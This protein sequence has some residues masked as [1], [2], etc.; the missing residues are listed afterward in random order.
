MGDGELERLAGEVLG[1]YAWAAAP[2]LTDPGGRG[3]FSGARL[4]RVRDSLAREAPSWYL[5][6]WPPGEP[7]AD[8]LAWIH[9]LMGRAREAG[10]EWVPWVLPTRGG[11]TAAALGGRLWEVGSWMP[12][13]ADYHDAPSPAR[14]RD[15][16]RVL[17]RLH[18]AWEGQD[19][20]RG[21][22][23]ALVRRLERVRSWQGLLAGGWLPRFGP[24]SL[25]PVTAAARLTWPLVVRE[26]ARVEQLVAPW[27]GRAFP[28]QPCLCD[29]W[30]DHVLFTGDRVTGVVDYGSIKVDHPAVDLARLLGSLC[31]DDEAAWEK[32][33]DAY[34]Q[35]R[36]LSA[37]DDELARVLDRTGTVVAAANWLT[38]LYHEHRVYPDRAAVAVR[39]TGLV[40]RLQRFA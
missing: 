5:R 4:W 16:C 28:L 26:M 23:P 13:R 39:L 33:L 2:R 36:P 30:H 9:H 7:A 27:Q 37:R 14:L 38:W 29:I 12:G 40:R 19:R 18:C 35:V 10:L 31:R 20:D 25:D 3:G 32:G 6:A 22:C 8:R 15:A 1:R 24:E 11:G 17:A 21:E 34:R